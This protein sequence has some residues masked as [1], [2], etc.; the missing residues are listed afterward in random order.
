MTFRVLQ[1]IE[2]E[3]PEGI[4][5]LSPGQ[6]IRLSKEEAFPLIENGMIV[7]IWKT[8]YRIYSG[9]LQ[10]YL[11]VV[12]TDEDMKALKATEKVTEPIYSAHE[13]RKLKGMGKEGLK[14]VHRAKEIFQD[15]KVETV[16][17]AAHSFFNTKAKTG[18]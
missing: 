3:T 9:I 11:W 17:R 14:A 8:Y 15:A 16:F 12:E 4:I 7:P 6:V 1:G 5:V 2:L 18:N 13:V 10:A